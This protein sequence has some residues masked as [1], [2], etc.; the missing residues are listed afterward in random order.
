ME[1]ISIRLKR[2]IMMKDN[3]FLGVLGAIFGA[4]VGSF[5]WILIGQIGFIA[6]I[7]GYAIVYC[8]IKGYGILG[9]SVS[10]RGI[11]I[12]V[13]LSLGM[14]IVAEYVSLGITIYRELQAE[15]YVTILDAFKFIPQLLQDSEVKVELMKNL[16]IGYGLAAWA[17]FSF[18]KGLWRE[19]AGDSMQELQE[20]ATID[21]YIER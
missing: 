5:L 15:Y 4:L 17:S 6:G 16:A 3:I 12:C 11:V 21:E 8:S 14:V 18:V 7:A 13:V 19:R 10:K 1:I 20:E 9:K 2:V